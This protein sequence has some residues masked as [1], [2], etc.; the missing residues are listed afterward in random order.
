MLQ[1]DTP[2]LAAAR[3]N[4]RIAAI[5]LDYTISVR[6][7][8]FS[9]QASA[10]W[11]LDRLDQPSLPLDGTYRYSLDGTGVNIYIL[12]TVWALHLRGS[13]QTYACDV[14]AEPGLS[15]IE[16][17]VSITRHHSYTHPQSLVCV[18]SPLGLFAGHQEGS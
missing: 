16:S 3:S 4:P 1:L 13:L 15:R 14:H 6:A 7:P 17:H 12:D 5:S 8:A 2:R 11:N 9:I 10:P 18:I